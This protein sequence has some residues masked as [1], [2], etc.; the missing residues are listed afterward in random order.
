M[1]VIIFLQRFASPFMDTLML[2]ISQLGSERAYIVLLTI[3]F[4][5]IDARI[6]RR[7]GLFLLL[8]FYI[9]QHLKA[10]VETARPFIVDPTVA[11]GQAAID[12]AAGGG[13]P[14]GHAQSSTTLW[15][16]TAFY[17]GRRWL[18]VLGSIMVLLVSLSRLYLGVHW[19]VD[20]LGGVVVGIA[21]MGFSIFADTFITNAL[22]MPKV[23]A[24]ILGIALPLTVNIFFPTPESDLLT[25]AFAAYVTAP[26]LLE[27][28]PPKTLWKKIVLALLGIILVFVFLLGSSM[29]LSEE[30]KRHPVGGFVRYLILGYMG[31]LVTPWLG[32]ILKLSSEEL[33]VRRK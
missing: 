18:W 8:S 11:R 15:G 4:L 25:G 9:N 27:H 20:V 10:L 19:V 7:L 33:G 26:L 24:F 2:A 17:F 5:A 23:L 12:T 16:L 13:F 3:I 21:V 28:R 6:G 14:S 30:I 1:E 29:L 31:L 22:K 32:R